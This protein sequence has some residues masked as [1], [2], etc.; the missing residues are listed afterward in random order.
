MTSKTAQAEPR[1]DPSLGLYLAR[2][3]TRHG[4]TVYNR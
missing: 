3:L 4:E 1:H 2:H